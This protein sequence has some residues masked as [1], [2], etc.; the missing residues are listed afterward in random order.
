MADADLFL[1]QESAFRKLTHCLRTFKIAFVSNSCKGGNN[2]KAFLF[3]V[4]FFQA[5]SKFLFL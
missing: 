3:I 4:L 2:N 1:A 5:H